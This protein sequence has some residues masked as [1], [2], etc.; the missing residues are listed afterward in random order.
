M[1]TFLLLI[2]LAMLGATVPEVEVLALDGTKTSGAIVA[3]TEQEVTVRTG[4]QS[5]TLPLE[6]VQGIQFGEP[7]LN[8]TADPA[9]WIT[10][11]DGS[12][13]VAEKYTVTEGVAEA[14][15][16]GGDV[17]RISTKVLRHVR[18]K[19]QNK[20][21]AEQWAQA[22]SANVAGDL[23]VIRKG[24]AIDYLEGVLRT[25]LDESVEFQLD[26]DWIP[27]GRKK[28]EGLV[29]SRVETVTQSPS[30][31]TMIDRAGSRIEVSSVRLDNDGLLIVTPSGVEV[32]RTLDQIERLEFIDENV[33]YLS[34]LTPTSVEWRPYFPVAA[35]IAEHLRTNFQPRRDRALG[36]TAE[37]DSALRL[38]VYHDRGTDVVQEYARGLAIASRT[39]I[40][41]ELPDGARRFKATVG[42]DERVA[43]MGHVRLVVSADDKVL[44]E[45]Y[46]TGAE[47]PQT[48]DV[49][50]SDA[51]ELS[52]LVDFGENY[53]TGDHLNLC[54]ARIVK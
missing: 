43:A 1:S 53:D 39:T 7:S 40:V 24:D 18:F 9:A 38:R 49:D 26:T 13:L 21:Q 47:S 46:V 12:V 31:G 19:Q 22:L 8:V 14:V 36:A 4:E 48:L 37:A 51:Q 20:N 33:I 54:E 45:G 35:V 10:L 17:V 23:L 34:D 28:V 44:F 41:F 29:Y 5:S 52:I 30:R 50:V 27:V 3:I 42:I 25:V 2:P 6:G 11:V 15:L 32:S 16:T